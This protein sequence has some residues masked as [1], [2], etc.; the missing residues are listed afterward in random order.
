[1]NA[2]LPQLSFISSGIKR[3]KF[4]DE[5]FDFIGITVF[6]GKKEVASAGF[7][8][9]AK[10]LI[11]DDW[12]EVLPTYQRLGI[13]TAMYRWAEEIT[14]RKVRPSRS[15]TADARAFWQAFR[16]KKDWKKGAWTF[17]SQ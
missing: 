13:A 14:G 7:R 12:T 8:V 16:K 5:E 1:M 9:T 3:L 10:S 6:H 17:R 11:D 2:P 4:G 15:R